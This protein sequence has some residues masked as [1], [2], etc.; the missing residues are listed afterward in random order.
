VKYDLKKP[1]PECPF[2]E[3]GGNP[4]R[5]RLGRVIEIHNTVANWHG[6]SFPCHKTVTYDD[7]G[8]HV[9]NENEQHCAGA[10]AYALKVGEVPQGTSF[11]LHMVGGSEREDYASDAVFDSFFDFK[12]SAIDYEAN[13]GECASGLCWNCEEWNKDDEDED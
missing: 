2:R 5:L 4:V 11:G 12:A 1:C 6:G 3:E 9:R 8:T 7:D 13:E 10:I